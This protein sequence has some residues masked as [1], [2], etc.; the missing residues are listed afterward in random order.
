MVKPKQNMC[1]GCPGLCCRLQVSLT[2]Y[3]IARI[4]IH[5][6]RPVHEFVAVA[7]A[8]HNDPDGFKTRGGIKKF[9]LIQKENNECIFLNIKDT[10]MCEVEN[11]KPAVCI[12]YPFLIFSEKPVLCPK[13]ACPPG[14]LLFLDKEKMSGETLADCKWEKEQHYSIVKD[15]NVSEKEKED[16]RDFLMFSFREIDL[17]SSALGSVFRKVRRPFLPHLRI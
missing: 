13:P 7:E 9:V 6:K 16:P 2:A 1:I 12:A 3:D 11:S 17:E 8:K 14:N 4:M 15:W 5:E 10:L